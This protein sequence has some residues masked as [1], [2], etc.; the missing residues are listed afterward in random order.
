[1]PKEKKT[2]AQNHT[3][4]IMIQT[5]YKSSIQGTIIAPTSKSYA[6]RAVAA[7]LLA[8]GQSTLR[9]MELCNDTRAALGVATALG[10]KIKSKGTTYTI[11]GGFNP[12]SSTLN[13]GESGL[14]TRLF[15]PIAALAQTPI[16]IT[17]EGSI[18]S[19]PIQAMS[20]PLTELGVEVTTSNGYLPLTVKGRLKGGKVTADGSLSSQFIT[21]LLTALPLAETDTELCV[22]NLQSIPY[23]DMTIDVLQHF[24]IKIEHNN[25]KTF[26]ISASQKYQA[27]DYNVEGDWSGAS[28]MLVAGAIAG[29]ITVENLN[30]NSLQADRKIMEA[31]IASGAQVESANNCTTIKHSALT[32]F[33]FDAT[34]C[35]D[36]FPALVALAANCTGQSKIIGTERLTHKESDRAATLASE[37][38]K[39]GIDVDISTP[40]VMYVRRG[41]APDCAVTADSH[42][43][44]RIAM[45]VAV[46]ALTLKHPV[47]IQHAEAVGKSYPDFWAELNKIIK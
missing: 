28:C 34:H 22:T 20:A 8:N 39:L 14:A 38:G 42:N 4:I 37:F 30:I 32:A 3:S 18:L 11:D 15:T 29:E 23:V 10:A 13:I 12:V 7:A 16:T 43:D 17:G 31:L 21:G 27:A 45:A 19:R 9:Y 24:G 26:Y 25:Y 36:L 1:M 44:H 40:N 46:A 41:T 47:T 33:E 35:P 2:F 6:Q 5:V